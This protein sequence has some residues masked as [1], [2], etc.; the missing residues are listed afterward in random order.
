MEFKTMVFNAARDGKVRRLR[1]FLEHRSR[2]EIA[3]IIAAKTN[4]A[5]PLLA[6]CRN[7]HLEVVQYLLERC[8]A[9][10]EL[11]GSVSF[12]GENIED[13]PPLWVAAAAGH[14]E[15]VRYLL[16]KGAGVNA[17]TRTN[18]TPL[19]AAC[20]DGHTE[21]VRCLLEAGADIE[22]ANRHGHTCLMISCYKGHIEIAQLLLDAGA[23]PNRKSVKGNTALHDC[24]ESGC[25]AIIQLLIERGAKM[26]V[27]AYGMTPLLA[28]AVCGHQEIVEYLISH[29]NLVNGRDERVNALE[30]LGATYV[31]RKRNITTACRIWTRALSERYPVDGPHIPKPRGQSTIAAF[32]NAV[33]FTT[34][35]ELMEVA[36]DP[37][38]LRMQALLIR[39]RI[40]G[41]AHPE[42]SYYLRYRGA[43]YA[44][45]GQFQRCLQLWMY[46][47]EMQQ[48]LLEP[49]NC[50]TLSSFLS[51]VELF[52]HMVSVRDKMS[53]ERNNDHVPPPLNFQEVM[54]V[55]TRC[56]R[57]ARIGVAYIEKL[58]A[59]ERELTTYQRI[60]TVIVMMVQLLA[61]IEPISHAQKTFITKSLY[62]T[63]KLKPT[64][65]NGM[66]LLHLSVT[67]PLQHSGH[68]LQS[69]NK[70]HA[71]ACKILIEAGCDPNAVD[72]EGRRALHIAAALFP[73]NQELVQQ[74][75]ESGAH[76]C[77][78]DSK[79][80]K[81]T[82]ILQEKKQKLTV[83]PLQY[84]SLKCLC[85]SVIKECNISYTGSVPS[86]LQTFLDVH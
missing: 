67:S 80:R 74:L 25:L 69:H 27:D 79:G 63:L 64:A 10:V 62:E 45:S 85:A 59:A 5:T 3:K 18:S 50:L 21:V 70:S 55:F 6:A 14:L 73:H 19:R 72:N 71:L 66:S 42:T 31:D 56:L 82:K 60:L 48:T 51:F 1:V 68:R 44:D 15:L 49:L 29:R 32:E 20:F 33:E 26:D 34:K 23:D 35:E 28:A 75:L 39:E 30:L 9:N 16:K 7:G 38:A 4:G 58:P 61:R 11:R 46:A 8:N 40:L 86:T 53:Q 65:R 41:P 24:A 17:V 57:E 2:D 83:N 84:M 54:A 13:A 37:D 81:F 22:L 76:F 47:L 43:V 77:S 52:N 78:P 12:D 36:S